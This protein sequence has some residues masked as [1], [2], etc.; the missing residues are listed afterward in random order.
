MAAT[1]QYARYPQSECLKKMFHSPF[2]TCNIPRRSKA[3]ATDTVY[4]NT[5]AIGT[6]EVM[7]QLF[8]RCDTMGTDIYGMKTGSQFVNTLQD[9]I[10]EQGAM[11]KLLSN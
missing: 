7:A 4:S 2:P 1:T 5:P 11:D 10:R 3:V 8:V 6:R 9:V